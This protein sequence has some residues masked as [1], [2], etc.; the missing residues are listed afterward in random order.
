MKTVICHFYNEEYL[1]P[2][3]LNHH[4]KIFDYGVMIN[5]NSTDNSV[6]IINEICPEWKIINTRNEFFSALEIDREIEDIEL[7]IDGWKICLNITEFI[8]GDFAELDTI[9]LDSILIPCCVMIESD[10][11]K[12]LP[13]YLDLPIMKQRRQG[14]SPYDSESNFKWRRAR[15]LHKNTTTYPIGRHYESYNTNNFLILWY[16]WSP[17]NDEIIKRKLQIQNKIPQLDRTNSWG[18]QHITDEISLIS[19]YNKFKENTTYLGDIIDKFY[20]L[21]FNK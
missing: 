11:E 16:G 15:N 2:F 20:N 5:Y 17:F 3:W 21:T 18:I 9:N 8:L 7:T 10:T 1:L 6:K 19:D 14:L 4:K 13:V 12:L